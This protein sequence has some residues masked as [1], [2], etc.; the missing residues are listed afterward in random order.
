MN[1]I[2]FNNQKI[3]GH[4]YFENHNSE[5]ELWIGFHNQKSK[6]KGISYKQALDEALCFGWIDGIRKSIDEHSYKIRFTPRTAKSIWSQ[7]NIKRLNELKEMSLMHQ[8]GIEVF[9]N[10][11]LKMENLYSHEQE[12]FELPL[13]FTEVFKKNL[14]AWNYFQNLTPSYKKQAIWWVISAKQEA[15]KLKRLHILLECSDNREKIP[16]LRRP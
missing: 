4:W 10:R 2:F 1:I 8:T 13:N 12:N 14:N 7:V 5:K 6:L 15:T 3:L 9:K 11:D 16:P